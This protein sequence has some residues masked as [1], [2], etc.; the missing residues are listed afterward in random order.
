MSLSSP[1]RS[2]NLLDKRLLWTRFSRSATT[3][4]LATSF[5]PLYLSPCSFFLCGPILSR[6]RDCAGNCSSISPTY[7]WLSIVTAHKRTISRVYIC[8]LKQWVVGRGQRAISDELS[9][10]LRLIAIKRIPNHHHTELLHPT[11]LAS[12]ESPAR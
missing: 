4:P 6:L 3:S 2:A 1:R 5:C 10:L 7:T 8:E 11:V 12:R 9:R